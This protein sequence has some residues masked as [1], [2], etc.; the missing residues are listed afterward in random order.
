VDRA[1]T[2]RLDLDLKEGLG[3]RILPDALVV[4]EDRNLLLGSVPPRNFDEDNEL[5]T[6]YQT[7]REKCPLQLGRYVLLR[8]SSEA[9][10]WTYQAVV[11]DVEK[12][13]SCRPGDVRRALTAAVADAVHRGA[14]HVATGP[15]GVWSQR[16]L[17]IEEM[18][19]A[20]D[21][22]VSE[23]GMRC[24]TPLRMT[25]L[26]AS[27]DDLERVSHQLR[28][29]VL[30]RASRSFRTVDGDAA[31]VEV[32]RGSNRL[33]YRFVPGSLSGYMVARAARS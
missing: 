10:W 4:Q 32:R 27:V 23:I 17:E 12:R 7:I 13:P 15:L 16:G 21:T 2:L 9:T 19:D 30:D 24:E 1:T 28:S 6:A 18:V 29:R 22:A 33:H 31:V 8:P 3:R 25:L 5:D 20:V 14:V 11:H 26:L